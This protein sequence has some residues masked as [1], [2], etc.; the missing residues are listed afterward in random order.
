MIKSLVFS[1]LFTLP[2]LGCTHT[3]PGIRI[4]V[5]HLEPGQDLRKE[6][7]AFVK[8][9]QIEAASILSAVGSLTQVTVRYANKD[10]PAVLKGHFEVV[11]LSGTTS[12]FGSHLHIAVA[13]GDG[14]ATGG[15]LV[16][17]SIVYTTMEIV[18]GVY[19][20]L[21]FRRK[22]DPASGYKELDVEARP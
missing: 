12:L 14:K 2:L 18:L 15:H 22:L 4:E 9:Q 17:G 16:D 3:E 7:D 10:N 8:A 1:F 11:A 5:V 19:P 6:I 20:R 13:D 21:S